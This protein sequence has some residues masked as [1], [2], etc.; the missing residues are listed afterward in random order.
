MR[1]ADLEFPSGKDAA[2]HEFMRWI[3]KV[4]AAT[5]TAI[6]LAPVGAASVLVVRLP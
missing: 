3:N 5:E 1:V 4:K 6:V 2:L